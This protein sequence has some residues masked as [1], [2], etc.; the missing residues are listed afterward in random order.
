MCACV[1]V[2]CVCVQSIIT[3][4][5]YGNNKTNPACTENDSNGKLCGQ[6]SLTEEEG[7]CTLPQKLSNC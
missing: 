4:M 6:W 3:S 2:V 7:E 1:C 5:D